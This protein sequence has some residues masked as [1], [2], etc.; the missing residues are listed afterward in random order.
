MI[1]KLSDLSIGKKA[2]IRSF[3]KNDN[4][5]KLLEMGIIPGEQIE[6]EKIAPFQDPISVNVAGYKLSLRLIESEGII[7]EE[8][9]Q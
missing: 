4:Y 3:E 5:I 6:V 9:N 1:K 7:V 8:I 2:I